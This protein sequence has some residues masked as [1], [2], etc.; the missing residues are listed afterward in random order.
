MEN[1]RDIVTQ[2][3]VL[4]SRLLTKTLNSWRFFL[5][6][7]LPPLAWIFFVVPSGIPCILI[8]LMTGIIW[9]R[10]WRLWLDAQYFS[11]INE[12]NNEQAGEALCFIW[13]RETLRTLTLVGRR[14]AALK[15]C[16]HTLYW[17]AILWLA[18]L[19]FL[20]RCW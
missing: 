20:L 5:L 13:Q 6:F 1:G 10:C 18:W 16:R 19:L 8:A 14:Y 12:D 11:L 9:F 3:S 4:L 15:Q 7:T 17:V 2:E